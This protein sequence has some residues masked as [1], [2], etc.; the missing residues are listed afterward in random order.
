MPSLRSILTITLLAATP[1]HAGGRDLVSVSHDAPHAMATADRLLHGVVRPQRE[2]AIAPVIDGQLGTISVEEGQ[3]VRAGDELARLDDRVARALVDAARAAAERTAPLEIAQ[4]ELAVADTMLKR[5]RSTTSM[6]ATSTATYEEALAR[7]RKARAA[8][9]AATEEMLQAQR[10]LELEQARYGQ[11]IMRAPFDGIVVRISAESG[12]ML[13]TKDEVLLLVSLEALETEI[14]LPVS[15]YGRITRGDRLSFQPASPMAALVTGTVRTVEPMIDPATHTF[16]VR[17]D[18][19]NTERRI[20]AG[21]TVR[22]LLDTLEPDPSQHA[23]PP[24][25]AA[26]PALTGVISS[27]SG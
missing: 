12:Q 14:H 18:I 10:A 22:P 26:S 6:G 25:P 24:A 11:H 27:T 9:D 20:P 13:M 7:A 17:F 15:W 23:G 8:C 19:H 5:L 3:V 2:V 21:L 16:R 1:V 4:S